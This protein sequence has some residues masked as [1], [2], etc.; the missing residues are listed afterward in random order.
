MELGQL[1]EEESCLF[2]LFHPMPNNSERDKLF[3]QWLTIREKRNLIIYK[4]EKAH[5]SKL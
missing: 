3:K 2:A 4:G 1:E 5:G